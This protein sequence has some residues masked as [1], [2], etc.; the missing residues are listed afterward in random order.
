MS[1]Y[2]EGLLIVG[3]KA[4]ELVDNLDN[5][6]DYAFDRD[7]EIT[8]VGYEEDLTLAYI[9]VKISRVNPEIDYVTIL[10]ESTLP[11]EILKAK[12][13]FKE[14]TGKEGLLISTFYQY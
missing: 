7:L 10:N 13:L 3:L 14:K 11:D 4:S 9:G 2:I 8:A 5:A 12:K 1:S 6:P